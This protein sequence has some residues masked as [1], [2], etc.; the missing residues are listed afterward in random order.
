MC[1]TKQMC[2]Y[3]PHSPPPRKTTLQIHVSLKMHLWEHFERWAPN[4][5]PDV[6]LEDEDIPTLSIYL[7]I[8]LSLYCWVIHQGCMSVIDDSVISY[9]NDMKSGR[10]SQKLFTFISVI[11]LCLF[12]YSSNDLLVFS[13]GDCHLKGN[14]SKY[15]VTKIE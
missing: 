1:Y 4:L 9:K 13:N 14:M 5:N 12:T 8:L 15:F 7:I 6:A 3:N 11:F 2:S 10:Q